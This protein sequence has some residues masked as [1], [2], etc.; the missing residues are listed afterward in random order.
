MS[1]LKNAAA[2]TP[3]APPLRVLHVVPS[4]YPAHGYGGPISALYE[5]CR[6]QVAA[7][8]A[9][10]VLTSDASGASRLTEL[11]GRWVTEL[12]VPTFYA[13][14]RI[15]EDIAPSLLWHLPTELRWAQ[16]VHVSGL[17]SP[18][19]L[20]G[21]SLSR[22]F[23]KPTVLT[24][25][26]ALMPWA[27]QSGR[28]RDRKLAVLR[29]LRPLLST[30]AGW[31]VSSEAEA[32]ALRELADQ[33]H[34][35]RA[36]P[37]VLVEHGV[38]AEE[39]VPLP[40][41]PQ[42][43][44]SAGL[45]ILVLGRIHPVK[46]LEL[47]LRAFAKLRET[48]PP[49]RLILAGPS[50]DADYRAKLDALATSLGIAD[51]VEFTGLVGPHEKAQLLEE[52]AVLWLCS[53]ME[54]FGVVALEALARGTPVV[55]VHGTPWHSLATAHLGHYVAPTPEA[56]ASATK[57]LL[58]LSSTEHAALR[59]RCRQFVAERYTWPVL[60]ARL[61]AFYRAATA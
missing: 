11:S 40:G 26:G 27:L 5:L 35:P 17:W 48:D 59:G 22:L 8:L 9:V 43:P 45:R 50:S 6:Q 4:F 12:G 14:V 39:L 61:Q 55:A 36:I 25:H 1:R 13:P 58:Q 7:G 42:R 60:E 57:E 33:G 18:T 24:P 2:P 52:A 20:L 3:P 10:R 49:Y 38:R 54:S 21:L 51:A 56:I 46:H 44:S 32:Q 53:H 19:S 47:A 29:T 31:H 16:L 23:G 30:L 41:L 34:L 28:G 15:G 37:I